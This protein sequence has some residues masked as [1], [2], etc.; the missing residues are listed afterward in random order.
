MKLRLMHKIVLMVFAVLAISITGVAFIST[1]KASDYLTDLAKDDLQHMTAMGRDICEIAI[2]H[3][4]DEARADIQTAALSASEFSG[5]AASWDG[6]H[7][8]LNSETFEPAD[9]LRLAKAVT[10]EVHASC[11]VWDIAHGSPK[12]LAESNALETDAGW[13]LTSESLADLKSGQRIAYSVVEAS[14]EKAQAGYTGVYD[15]AGQLTAVL[16]VVCPIDK[17]ILRATIL[18]QEVGKTGY[19]YIMDGDAVLKIHPTSE[20]KGI[21]QYDFAKEMTAK[22]NQLAHN[23]YGWVSYF[24]DRDGTQAEKIV[25]YAYVP[26][27]DWIVATGSYLDEFTSPVNNIQASIVMFGA[28]F[29]LFSLGIGFYMA[30]TISRPVS[31][32]AGIAKEL[33]E[34]DINQDIEIQ[35]SDEVGE[36]ANAFRGMIEYQKEMTKAAETIAEND[37]TVRVKPRSERDQLGNAFSKM[38]RNLTGMVRQL[39]ENA[40][41]LVSAATEIASS[42]EQM[43]RGAADQAQQMTQVAVALEEMSATIVQSSKNANEATEASGQAS[44]TAAGGGQ[45]VS[46]TIH[47][48]NQIAESTTGVSQIVDELAGSAE[49]IGEIITVIDDIADQTNLL[50]LNAAIEAARAGEQGRGFAVVADEV[51]KLAERTGKAT[52]EITEMIKSIQEGTGRAVESMESAGSRVDEGKG[53]ADQAGNALNEIVNVVQQ[54]MDMIQQIA[55]ATEEQ[56]SAAEEI[57]K[58]VENVSSISKEAASGAEQSAAAAEELNR[59]AEGMQQMVAVFK[60]NQ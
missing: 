44:N 53:L 34:G 23:G 48:M 57:S 42:S 26:E 17:E 13:Q 38:I 58:N 33:S 7:M 10:N 14:G 50:A 2:L 52:G 11:A 9:A 28:I 45:I 4:H 43:S 55:T 22:A 36:L 8:V 40:G 56:S 37:L 32:M 60:V 39:G 18:G 30:R 12:L 29:M 27:W 47:G 16:G 15:T 35:S 19:I 41:Q 51:R 59:Q 21:S 3:A 24:W 49:Q 5:G 25:C 1:M 6:T 20:G 46:D 31:Q 54:V